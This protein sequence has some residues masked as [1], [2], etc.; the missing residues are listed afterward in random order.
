MSE[1]K[2]TV[3]WKRTAPDF[4][5]ETYDRTHTIR[6]EGGIHHDASAAKEF[7]GKAELANP[8]ELFA[9]ALASCHMLTFLAV[10]SKSRLIVDSYTDTP[11]AY[12]EKNATGKL[13]VT[14]TVLHPRVVFAKESPVTHEKLVELHDKA[15]RNCFIA[16]S[17]SGEVITEIVT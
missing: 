11:I 8:E 3:T 13:A 4:L 17:V 2:A 16:N 10:A 9:G 5:Y 14:K 6:Y 7:M 1:H 12:L 15:H